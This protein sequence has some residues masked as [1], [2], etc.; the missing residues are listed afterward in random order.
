MLRPLLFVLTACIS[1]SSIAQVSILW[2]QSY[3]ST[4]NNID[5]SIEM[6]LDAAGNSYVTGIGRGSSGNFDIV[7]IKYNAAGVQQWISSYN[8]VGNGLD[9][10][11]GIAIDAANNIYVVGWT[12]GASNNYNYVTLKYNGT[13]GAQVWA[14][15]FNG[16]A[17]T[18]DDPYDIG[19]DANANVYVT[20]GSNTTTTGEDY[21]TVKYDSAGVFQ[22]TRLYS[23]SGSNI[24]KARALCIDNNN[25]I[26]VT[27]FSTG[28]TGG[29]DYATLKY[30]AA[31]TALW[32]TP[33]RYNGT[34]NNDD[35]S[36]AIAV[37]NATG[38]VYIT[39]Y[40]R[41]TAITDFDW[42]TVMVNSLGV[43]QW[44]QRYGGS[45]A[46]LDRAN[47]LVLDA[48]GNAY[49]T[50][51]VKNSATNEDLVVIKYNN[52][53]AQQWIKSYNGASNYF[54]EG[55]SLALNT[56]ETFI[57][58]GGSS[59]I[60]TTLNDFYTLKLQTSDGAII[61]GT[62]YNGPGNGSD[63]NF[64]LGLDAFENVY[65]TGQ[66][67]GSGSGSDFMTIKYCQLLAS[68][69]TDVSICLNASVQLNASAPGATAYS[70][71]PSTGLSN[72]TI[73]NPIA[74]PT[75]TTNYVVT[76]TNAN[77]CTDSD[78][79]TVTVFPLPGPSI[80]ASGP[81]TFCAGDSVSL[82]GPANYNYLW[83]PGGQTTQSITVTTSN[84]YTLTIS[85]TN[86]CAAQ[87]TQ[88]VT[89]NPLPNVNAGLN[90]T[91]CLSQNSQLNATGAQ[92]YIWSPS[93]SL[94]NPS[95]A[96]PVAG[97]VAST[98]Y[99]VIGTDLN[100][101]S[102][103]DTVRVVV[104]PNPPVPTISYNTF[105]GSLTC[106]QGGYTYQWYS[107]PPPTLIPGATNQVYYPTVNGNYYVVI[108]DPF[109]CFTASAVDSATNVGIA[110]YMDLFNSSLY[111]NPNNGS[112]TV[113]FNLS[114]AQELSI[115]VMDVAGQLLYSRSLNQASGEGRE[116][117]DLTG[118]SSGIYF[119]KLQGEKGQVVK[120]F[121]VK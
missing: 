15:I 65:V 101:C 104:N 46:E 94:S 83:Q 44:V 13:S 49:V 76:I 33:H 11:R 110:E 71:T 27:G 61:W 85:D 74:N 96:N 50:G 19:I 77:G 91:V 67:T 8:G 35:E 118:L 45:A 70:W 48:S 108:Y 29:L 95:I 98:T 99:T 68:A 103:S 22:W 107:T 25:N 79:V 52:T 26:Y 30:D 59:N 87:S 1:I 60:G 97:P 47:D 34:G 64:D 38:D 90:D 9:E 78:T 75:V 62:R 113:E 58:V 109:G 4:G 6:V 40:S 32:G 80:T 37:N 100:G 82:S 119:L 92:N 3:T 116:E 53:G 20:G 24:D 7:T 31:G 106:L 16:T 23:N 18:T 93:G 41:N 86:T 5:R 121:V 88:S 111:P 43:Q 17:N 73:S 66:R 120:R 54:D 72:T 105:D 28:V 55:I 56:A 69:G 115:Q 63:L 117:I 112:F 12:A 84:T 102:N 2:S 36:T 10:A 57:Y 42:A 39:G 114:V 89:V 14:Q 21:A 51:K 81:T